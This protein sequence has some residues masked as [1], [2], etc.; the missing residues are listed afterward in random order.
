MEALAV[1]TVLLMLLGVLVAILWI[2]LPFAVFGMKPLLRTA[3]EQQR[4][5]NELLARLDASQKSEPAFH[6]TEPGLSPRN[7]PRL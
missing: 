1:L 4:R 7:S 5:T 6:D 2:L 3:I